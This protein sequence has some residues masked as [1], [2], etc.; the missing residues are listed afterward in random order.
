MHYM[1]MAFGAA[2]WQLFRRSKIGPSLLKDNNWTLET[3]LSRTTVPVFL[4]IFLHL[5][6]HNSLRV[7]Q[8]ILEVIF[9]S[10]FYFALTSSG[11]LF[12]GS[13]LP[14][15]A[16]SAHCIPTSLA[17]PGNTYHCSMCLLLLCS[18]S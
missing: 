1:N 10:F 4:P 5:V 15:C 14:S 18:T 8:C 11:G 2:C 6:C 9:V 7:R 3:V 16:G 12:Q 13:R 17:A